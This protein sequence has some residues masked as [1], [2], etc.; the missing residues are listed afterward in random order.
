MSDSMI[1]ALLRE[2]EGYAARGMDDRV[3]QVDA[4]LEAL[5][6]QRRSDKPARRER[7][8][9]SAPEKRG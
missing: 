4:Q 2:R 3:A 6:H 9:K 5:G 1:A 8:V 7:A